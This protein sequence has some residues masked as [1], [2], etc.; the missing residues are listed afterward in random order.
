MLGSINQLSNI[1][2]VFFAIGIPFTF[3][4]VVAYFIHQRRLAREHTLRLALDKSASLSPE[5]MRV[6]EQNLKSSQP[7]RYGGIFTAFLFV[8]L[9]LA[10]MMSGRGDPQLGGGLL[11]TCMGLGYGV[12][13]VL[14]ARSAKEAIK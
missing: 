9:G 4:G 5:L 3:A 14:N 1:A 10:A 13:T 8:G 6:I 2:I 12:T 11:L 7:S